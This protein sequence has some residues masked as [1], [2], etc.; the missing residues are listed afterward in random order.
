MSRAAKAEPA[1][2]AGGPGLEG[3][4]GV[5]E[6]R[7][8]REARRLDAEILSAIRRAWDDPLTEAEF[9]SLARGL[10]AHQARY[11][12]VASSWWE[13][14]GARPPQLGAWSDI[15]P[16]PVSAFKRGR[17]A[18]F[19]PSSGA[20]ADP[21]RFLS[22]GTTAASR[23]RVFVESLELYRAAIVPPFRRH[24]LPDRDRMSCVFLAPPPRHAPHSSLSFMFE[25]IRVEFGTA[26]SS[27]CAAAGA[28]RPD[29]LLTALERA[30]A[31]GEPLFLLGPA[32]AFVQALDAFRERGWRFDL[33]ESSRI[34][35]TGGFKGR[36]RAVTRA[37]LD[38]AYSE[39]LG[40]PPERVVNEYGMAELASQFY[41][42]PDGLYSAPPWVRWR[43]LDP[44]TL[45]RAAE[46]SPGVLAVW[47]LANRSS[48]FAL[49][50]EDLAIDRGGVFEI[51]GR[52]PDAEPRGCSLEAEQRLAAR[53]EMAHASRR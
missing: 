10:F 29:R 20:A 45:R 11:N 53:G 9:D 50:T 13:P 40:I 12:P 3:P 1:S 51:L 21:P 48:C 33:P 15:A 49:R 27:F 41:A 28:L 5:D 38:S 23:S 43:V 36:S 7:R 32:F 24:C 19:P 52:V 2:P 47:D 42:G 25:V 44:L 8:A 35:Q 37:E 30:R 22:S 31:A 14:P 39:L 6:S 26:R 46:G 4:A 18:A 34:F 16:L 17:V